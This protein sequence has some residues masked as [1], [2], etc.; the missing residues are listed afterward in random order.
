M[1]RTLCLMENKKIS[2][3]LK[4]N[5]APLLLSEGVTKE[6]GKWIISIGLGEYSAF[7]LPPLVLPRKAQE[8]LCSDTAPK[9]CPT[10]RNQ[11]DLRHEAVFF[12][13]L[14]LHK[15]TENKLYKSIRHQGQD[16][17]PRHSCLMP[18]SCGQGLGACGS[19]WVWLV[20]SRDVAGKSLSIWADTHLTTL[21]RSVRAELAALS[22]LLVREGSRM[23]Q[24][25][26]EHQQR[27]QRTGKS[28]RQSGAQEVIQTFWHFLRREIAKREDVFLCRQNIFFLPCCLV[29]FSGRIK[30]SSI[31]TRSGHQLCKIL[32]KIVVSCIVQNSFSFLPIKL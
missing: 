9:G 18:H 7:V 16:F 5:S 15:H 4:R 28:W 10:A 6:A 24:F 20:P 22:L 2:T 23:P 14:S 8:Q 3:E 26:Y 29:L 21:D 32:S 1:K 30:R 25:C 19:V 27:Q 31:L 13:P 11:R 12:S 17:V